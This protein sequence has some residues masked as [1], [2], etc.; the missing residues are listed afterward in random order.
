MLVSFVCLRF[1]W[2]FQISI[3]LFFFFSLLF[4]ISHFFSLCRVCYLLFL[5]YISSDSFNGLLPVESVINNNN[6][7]NNNNNTFH[8]ALNIGGISAQSHMLLFVFPATLIWLLH[9]NAM[10]FDCFSLGAR[11][12]FQKLVLFFFM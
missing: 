11:H 3:L 4:Y 7:N 10:P 8:F 9:C 5:L 1:N 2:L 6:N 12:L